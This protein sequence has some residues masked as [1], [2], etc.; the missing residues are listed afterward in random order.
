MVDA[1]TERG[2]SGVEHGLPQIRRRI[3]Q[4]VALRQSHQRRAA[5]AFI[6]GVSAA[7]NIARAANCRYPDAR[8]RSEQNELSANVSGRYVA[9]HVAKF[10]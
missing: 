1:E 5:R 4:Q 3:D 7:A 6:A 2:S 10:S 9:R 8:S